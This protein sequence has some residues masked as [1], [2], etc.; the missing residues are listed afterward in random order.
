LGSTPE[1]R[2]DAPPPKLPAS[3]Q[4]PLDTS[5]NFG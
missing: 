2:L 1:L 5:G 4:I 3:S